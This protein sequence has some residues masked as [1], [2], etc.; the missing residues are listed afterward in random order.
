MRHQRDNR[1][2]FR[3]LRGRAASFP[4]STPGCFVN[5]A[6][7]PRNNKPRKKLP[8][9]FV[10]NQPLVQPYVTTEKLRAPTRRL[11]TTEAQ[12]SDS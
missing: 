3:R 4:L 2:M 1:A 12:Q 6:T 5:A 8:P 10:S 7:G 11:E 9:Q